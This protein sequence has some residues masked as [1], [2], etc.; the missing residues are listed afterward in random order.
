MNV[1]LPVPA[2]LFKI[3]ILSVFTIFVVPTYI[4]TR[5]ILK[6]FKFGN[7]NCWCEAWIFL[8]QV[9]E[10]KDRIMSQH[11]LYFVM[12]YSRLCKSKLDQ[13]VIK[14]NLIDIFIVGN[15]LWVIDSKQYFKNWLLLLF[16]YILLLWMRVAQ[17]V[18]CNHFV[19]FCLPTK[20]DTSSK[21]KESV[22]RC[23]Q[24]HVLMFSTLI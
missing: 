22:A 3:P 17:K 1:I 7:W 23:E 12:K 15:I 18:Q 10:L 19:I 21:W 9:F 4:P 5:F 8:M 14:S 16:L 13:K 2:V 6:V 24:C 11:N 20:T